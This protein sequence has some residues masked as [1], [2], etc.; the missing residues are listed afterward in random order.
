MPP[1][2]AF[3]YCIFCHVSTE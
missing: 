3:I 1:N 2:F